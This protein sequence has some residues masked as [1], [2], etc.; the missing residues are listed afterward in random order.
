MRYTL[1]IRDDENAVISSEERSRRAAGLT[2][3][4]QEMLGPA[5]AL[6]PAAVAALTTTRGTLSVLAWLAGMI[7]RQSRAARR[8]R[9]HQRARR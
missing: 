8:E 4:Q 5:R 2:T 6:L 3:F 1:L 7:I 9:A